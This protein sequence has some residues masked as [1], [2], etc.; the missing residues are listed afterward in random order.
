MDC[1]VSVSFPANHPSLPG[2]FPH[3]P[4]VPGVLLLTEVLNALRLWKGRAVTVLGISTVKFFSPLPPDQSVEIGFEPRSEE[5]VF[6]ECHSGAHLISSGVI[7]IEGTGK[8]VS[9]RP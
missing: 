4:V 9:S 7:E 1:F 2:H 3:N 6:F 8:E 5:S